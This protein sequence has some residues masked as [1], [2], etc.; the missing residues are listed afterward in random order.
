MRR[1]IILAVPDSELLDVV[2][3]YEVFANAQRALSGGNPAPAALASGA[4]P[5]GYSVQIAAVGGT[6]KPLATEAGISI[7]PHVSLERLAAGNAAI[8]T[9]IVAGGAGARRSVSDRA[10]LKLVQRVASRSRRVASVCTGAFI[11]AAAGLLSGKRATTHWAFCAALAEQFPSVHVERE[12]IY[13]RDGAHWTSAGVTAGIDLALAMVEEDHGRELG[14]LL[15]RWLVVFVRRSGGQAQFSAQLSA[16]T[17]ERSALRELQ[18]SIVERPELSWDV[19]SL[20]RRAAMSVRHFSRSFRAETGV[21]PAAYVESVRVETARRLLES[22]EGGVEEIAARSG[23]G[24]PE[25]LRRAFA[26]R[27]GVSPR[28]YRARF[29]ARARQE[30]RDPP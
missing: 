30:S 26:R 17:A 21:S 18:S 15:A 9:F 27:V 24:T 28:E 25:A 10:L 14:L 1:I 29:G 23:F 3:P 6:R 20:A 11:L 4:R 13:V 7:Q 5:Q 8:D 16:Q 12:P 19:P 22:S 2:G